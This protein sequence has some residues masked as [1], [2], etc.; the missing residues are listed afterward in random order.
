MSVDTSVGIPGAQTAQ[1]PVVAIR[2]ITTI[3]PSTG[4]PVQTQAVVLVDENSL[5]FMAMSEA[6]GRRIVRTLTDIEHILRQGFGMTI[7]QRKKR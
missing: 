2:T 5:E 6:T 3:D 4:Q 7:R 1:A